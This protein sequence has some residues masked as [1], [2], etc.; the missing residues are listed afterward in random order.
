[1]TASASSSGV[2]MRAPFCTVKKLPLSYPSDTG[3]KR[4]YTMRL[5]ETL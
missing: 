5:N 2:A 3:M 1:M 4:L